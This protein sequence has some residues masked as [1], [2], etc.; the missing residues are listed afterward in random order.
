MQMC[1][2]P[3]GIRTYGETASTGGDRP[4]LTLHLTVLYV[5]MLLAG[6]RTIE[7]HS[8]DETPIVSRS[9]S[10][11]VPV[12]R[13]DSTLADS[14]LADGNEPIEADSAA[15]AGR[16][17][18]A[19]AHGEGGTS[20]TLQ[21]TGYE[22]SRDAAPDAGGLTSLTLDEAIA[23][24]LERNP[25]LVVV[26]SG[27]S[28]AHAA[29]H[30][31][32]TYPFNPQFQTQ[33]LPYTRDPQG[34][35]APVSQ[36][37]VLVQ[38]FELG[39]QSR[40]RSG[41]A[42]ASLE[43]VRR[44]IRQAELF[45]TAQT[46][47]LYFTA[48]YQRELLEI[49]RSLAT[50]NDKLV[51]VMERRLKAGQ[52]NN[53]DVA[54]ARLQA[55]S[56]RRQQRLMK[57]NYQTA[58]MNL[59][60][61]L[62]FAEGAGVELT[63]RWVGWQWRS[64]A[65]VLRSTVLDSVDLQTP[66]LPTDQDGGDFGPAFLR[67]IVAERPDVAAARAGVTAA[68]ENLALAEAMRSP[69]MQLGPMW[70]RDNTATQYWGVQ[71]QINLPVV[72]TGTPLVRQRRAE[73]QQQQVTAARLEEKAV[74]EARAAIRRYERA[75]RLVEQSRGEFARAIPDVLKPFEDQFQAGQISLLQVFSARTS[76]VQ[77]RQSFLDL[78]NELAQSA[79]DVTLTTALPARQLILNPPPAPQTSA[80]SVDAIQLGAKDGQPMGASPM[81]PE[82]S[83]P[84]ALASGQ[85]RKTSQK[86]RPAA[87]A[88]GSLLT[89]LG[90]AGASPGSRTS[91]TG[92]SDLRRIQSTDAAP[93]WRKTVA[94]P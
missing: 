43:Q 9:E 65:D 61:Y 14:T 60:S 40:F 1:D 44:T 55:E 26:R 33:V 49:N 39:G 18:D 87:S 38:T 73:L 89:K 13:A 19:A 58:L 67:Q 63:D 84:N 6:C 82:L 8:V 70:Q 53:A 45:T 34:N 30:V 46:E 5:L 4:R 80:V 27:E 47:R 2:R 93:G 20:N 54:L 78:L 76:L 69:N 36:Q 41:A 79:A 66:G 83:E 31:A 71:A 37:H 3:S 74:L 7:Q 16:R 28:V 29:Y 64:A 86:T 75:R 72:N 52:A 59:R 50:L 92:A 81:A 11:S 94:K 51:G 15:N 23:I 77:S 24:S 21:L 25:D 68:R 90:P 22:V 10:G 57:A 56:S 48:L 32:K 42:A 35:D 91:E 88:V 12:S 17:F 85:A 62:N